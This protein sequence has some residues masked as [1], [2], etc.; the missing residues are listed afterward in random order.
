MTLNYQKYEL[1]NKN[2]HHWLRELADRL[3]FGE[4][5][6]RA[7]DG[8]REGHYWKNTA[9]DMAR[10]QIALADKIERGLRGTFGR[11]ISCSAAPN[12]CSLSARVVLPHHQEGHLR[13]GVD[14]NLT[15]L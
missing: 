15:T 5:L 12:A 3:G 4:E 10:A 2:C 1:D 11:S 13:P 9:A 6:R 7:L 14:V 8:K